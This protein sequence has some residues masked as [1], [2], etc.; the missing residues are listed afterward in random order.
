MRVLFKVRAVQLFAVAII[1]SLI[2]PDAF[3]RYQPKPGRPNF[4]SL[5]QEVQMGQ[6]EAAKVDQQMPL[7]TD[8]QLNSY[9]QHL[10]A[11]LAAA[12]PGPKYPYTFK[13]VNQSDINAFALPGGPIHVNLGTIQAADNEAQLAGVMAHEMSHVIMRH[14]T[15]M[16]SQQM[17]A[18]APLSIL[19]GLMGNGVGAQLA[20]LGISFAAGSVFLKYSRDAEKQA[21]LVGTDIMHDA[22]FDPGQLSRFFSKLQ[23]Q[24]GS[25]GAQFLSDHPNPGNRAEYILAEA[26]TLTAR[27]YSQDSAEFRQVKQR[28]SGMKGLTAQQIQQQQ[29]SGTG[30]NNQGPPRSQDVN[31]G[32]QMKSL[33]HNA[34]TISYPANWQVYGDANSEVTIAPQDG[35]TQ[36]AVAYG[37]IINGFEA[38]QQNGRNGLDDMTHQLLSELRQSNPDL[39]QVG[40]DENTSVNGTPAKSVILVGPSPIMG[41]N[42]RPVQERDWLV[43]LQRDEGTLVYF[44]FIAPQQD[45]GQLQPTFEQ[46]LRSVR[47]K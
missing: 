7:V 32:G 16:A 42:N 46:M 28:V 33:N 36:N 39:R 3:A 45:F 2:I 29:K 4:F 18:Q 26:D 5:D 40:H 19:G 22:G 20:Q 34:Y 1:F 9:I 24:S 38:E 31:P 23:E 11:R 6:Q 47:L 27:Q 41:N 30:P 10:G 14:S 43:A 44:V 12:A 21:D 8:P 37:V 35:I 13:I 25:R 15:H 17:L